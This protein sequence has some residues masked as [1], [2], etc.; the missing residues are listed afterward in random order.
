MPVADGVGRGHDLTMDATLWHREWRRLLGTTTELPCAMP[1]T[2]RAF[3]QPPC[4]EP[5]VTLVSAPGLQMM[6]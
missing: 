6:V 3:R 5:G 1:P 4:G 2:R